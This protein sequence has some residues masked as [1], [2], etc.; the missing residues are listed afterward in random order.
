MRPLAIRA[1]GSKAPT[2]EADLNVHNHGK[3]CHEPKRFSFSPRH[4]SSGSKAERA[5]DKEILQI[6]DSK[7]KEAQESTQKVSFIQ[8]KIYFLIIPQ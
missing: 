1:V 4:F 7:V 3:H 6:I 2:V 8:Y 5:V